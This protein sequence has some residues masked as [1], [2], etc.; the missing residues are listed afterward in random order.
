MASV[1][2]RRFVVL[3]NEVPGGHG[4]APNDLAKINDAFPSHALLA[5][6]N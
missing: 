2:Y 5:D 4:L 1:R 6:H 3:G